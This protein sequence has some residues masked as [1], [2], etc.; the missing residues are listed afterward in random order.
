[1]TGRTRTRQR[2][3]Q[4]TLSCHSPCYNKPLLNHTTK[5]LAT[6]RILR[7]QTAFQRHS[8][9]PVN[10]IAAKGKTKTTAKP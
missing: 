7:S 10:K 8:T 9:I 3:C 1:M 5:A 4:S 2:A 6:F